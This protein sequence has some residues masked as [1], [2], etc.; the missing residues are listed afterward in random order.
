MVSQCNPENATNTI[1]AHPYKG[2]KNLNGSKKFNSGHKLIDSYAQ[3]NL[4]AQAKSPGSGVTVLLDNDDEEKLAGYFTITAHSL[5]RSNF[6]NSNSDV[7]KT[8]LIPV[9]RLVM[10]GVD[11]KHQGKGLGKRLMRLAL[12][13]TK[14]VALEI[15]CVGMYL[16]A[17]SD[18]VDFYSKLG[19]EALTEPHEDTGNVHMFLHLDK[20]PN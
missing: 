10:L 2:T 14:R 19:F 18:A 13:N 9:V 6:A 8:P 1:T 5:C 3:K 4:R 7:G 12:E 16:E 11:K 20:I 17:D 15:N